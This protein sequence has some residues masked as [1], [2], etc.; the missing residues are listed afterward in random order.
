MQLASGGEMLNFGYWKGAKIT[1]PIG[2]QNNICSLIGDI[3]ELGSAIRL[4]DVGSGLSAPAVQWKSVYHSLDISCININFHQLSFALAHAEKIS[5]VNATSTSLPFCNKS[6]DRVVALESAQHFRPLDEFIKES[7]RILQPKGLL[8]IAIP[9]VTKTREDRIK[10]LLNL[11]ILSLTWSSEHYDLNYI[12]NIIT[13]N[14]FR[15]K[16]IMH[17]GHYVYEPLTDYYILNRSALKAKILKKYSPFLE[18]ILYKSLLKMKDVSKRGIID[19]VIIK[20]HA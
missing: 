13:K 18:S 11:G 20:A 8:I 7:K 17:I 19:Y 14:G 15:I 2:A 5:R 4:V 12:E 9:I 6:V 16:D 10:M 3:A 1:D